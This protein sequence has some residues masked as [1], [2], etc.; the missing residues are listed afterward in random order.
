MKS[1]KNVKVSKK[2]SI[3]KKQKNNK[4]K[5]KSQ[6][7]SVVKDID[8]GKTYTFKKNQKNNKAK[9]QATVQDKEGSIVYSQKNGKKRSKLRNKMSSWWRQLKKNKNG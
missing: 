9:T 7:S 6:T 5:T 4:A 1:P 8:T 3:V 2:T